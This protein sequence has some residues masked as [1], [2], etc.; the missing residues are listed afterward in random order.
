MILK[1]R[2]TSILN[3]PF[4]R[5]TFKLSASTVVLI[6]L[7]ILVTPILTRLYT[8][9]DY[10]IWG[11][12]SS[13]SMIITSILFF[14]YENAIIQTDDEEEVPALITLSILCGISVV[15]FSVIVFL[16]GKFLGIHFF[17][18]FPPLSY[19]IVILLASLVYNLL[20]IIANRYAFYNSMSI[21]NIS[22]GS[23]QA[24]IRILLQTAVKTK[25]GLI[26]GNVLSLLIAA[27]V[28]G[29]KIRTYYTQEKKRF[30]SFVGIKKL[31]NKYKKYPLFDAPARLI[32][33][34]I[35]NIV[36]LLLSAYFDKGD[37]GCYS[38]LSQIMILPITLVG[39]AMSRVSFRELSESIND[40]EKFSILANRLIRICVFLSCLPIV[41][42]V[43]GGDYLLVWILG[44]GWQNAGKMS[45]CL[46]LF[47][48]PVILSE[49]LQPI[50]KVFNKQN[51]RFILNVI[52]L[53][54]MVLAIL[55]GIVFSHNI[56]VVLILFSIS[57]GLIR[58]VLFYYEVKI[59]GT[60]IHINKRMIILIVLL[61]IL[62]IIRLY[63]M[64]STNI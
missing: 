55:A 38:L 46:A 32:E 25:G 24:L 17:V 54:I 2:I 3:I 21:A 53:F 62:L 49:P 12:L 42:F 34:T 33:F 8:P 18:S 22:E 48:V 30:I 4:I 50:F 44:D 16:I 29:A 58:L 59:M 19:L 64:F 40:Q 37:I 7:S 27:C 45:L 15:V 5:N 26:W 57:Y 10:G 60:S 51:I 47:S 36:V 31:I 13:A 23:S 56:Y 35:G 39:T 28:L 43:I 6:G 1:D 63:F 9:E 61:Y 14:S 11:V 41:F 20:L 52:G